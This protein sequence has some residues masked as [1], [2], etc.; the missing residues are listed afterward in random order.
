M[1]ILNN[2]IKKVREDKLDKFYTIPSIA[3]DCINKISNYYDWDNFDLVIEPSIGSGSF[4]NQLP[5]KNKLG[6]D[7]MPDYMDENVKK[8]DFLS[9]KLDNNY[10][11]VMVVG[12]PPFGKVSSLA[13]KFFNHASL[14]SNVNVIC[15]IIPRTFRKA[16]IKNKLNKR[17]HLVYD[18]DINDKPCS[19]TPKMNVK[20]CFQI[21]EKR[22]IERE[23]IVLE[24]SHKDWV[25]LNH[26]PKDYKN[27]P[28]PPKDADFAIRAYGGKCGFIE[29]K[30]AEMNKL[31]AKNWHWIKANIDVNILKN[32]FKNIDYSTSKNTAR[33]NSIGKAELVLLYRNIFDSKSK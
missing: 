17:F 20:C 24:T 1:S 14:M 7:I 23:E 3:L 27:Q 2:D 29:C 32:R 13:V 22:E 12:N 11:N 31:R 21:W 28:T 8:C 15:F 30:K 18:V 19:F 26:G 5:T 4:Y 6:I 16:S 9:Y 25:F 33:Q 10:N